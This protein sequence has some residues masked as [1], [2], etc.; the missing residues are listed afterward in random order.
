LLKASALEMDPR[1][2]NFIVT[3]DTGQRKTVK[4]SK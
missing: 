4:P 1:T 2:G 3:D